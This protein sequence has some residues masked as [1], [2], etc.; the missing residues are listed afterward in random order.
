MLCVKALI[1]LWRIFI[2]A[3][4]TMSI[5]KGVGAGVAA[6]MLFGLVSTVMMKNNHRSKRKASKAINTAQDILD[7][8]QEM[9]K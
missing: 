7:G 1:I 8:I 2:M 9:F 3:R 5:V 4:N 6:G